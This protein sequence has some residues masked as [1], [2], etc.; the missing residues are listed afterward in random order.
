MGLAL[1]SL[2]MDLL[3]VVWLGPK[4]AVLLMVVVL[5]PRA[6]LRVRSPGLV[7]VVWAPGLWAS[8][9]LVVPGLG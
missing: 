2:V 4:V 1:L 9:E 7:V 3:V 6:G 8:L 5:D